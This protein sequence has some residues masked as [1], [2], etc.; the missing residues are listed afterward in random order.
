M[1]TSAN[2][3]YRLACTMT[4]AEHV[5]ASWLA[6]AVTG[7]YP[8]ADL[9]EVQSYAPPEAVIVVIT[10]AAEGLQLPGGAAPSAQVTTVEEVELVSHPADVAA[11]AIEQSEYGSAVKLTLAGA[12]IAVVVYFSNRIARTKEHPPP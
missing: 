9:Y 11:E 8:D 5:S 2:H 4:G 10:A 3:Y 7:S 12:L 1:K 6:A